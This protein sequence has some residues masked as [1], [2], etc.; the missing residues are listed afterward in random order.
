VLKPYI[1][2]FTEREHGRDTFIPVYKIFKKDVNIDT[3]LIWWG[4]ERKGLLG[5]DFKLGPIKVNRKP[6]VLIVFR[7]WWGQEGKAAHFAARQ[8]IPVVMI[9]HGA[10]FVFNDRQK[11]KKSIYPAS[12]N[13]LWGQHDLDLW[14][15]WGNKDKLVVTGNPLYDQIIE[16]TP[17][18]INLPDEFALLLPS[19]SNVQQRFLIPSAEKLNKII[20]VVVKTHPLEKEKDYYKQRYLT[21]DKS[22]TL[23]PL[24][25]KAK[26][27]ITH[28][29]SAV[30]PGLFWQ[31]PI[32]MHSYDESWYYFS[33]FKDKYFH[34]FNF[35]QD[36]VWNSEVISKAIKPD[37]KHFEI[38]GHI[39]DGKN[40]VRV[41]EVIKS[42][43]K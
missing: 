34:I 11:Y 2:F 32:F 40:S 41:A 35:K 3:T 23:L 28:S 29:T 1:V 19:S 30:I 15:R 25:Y 18:K 21:Y 12:V 39:A 22:W 38:F 4:Q 14:R 42:Y 37:K 24:L 13:C 36:D 20:P 27:I 6:D 31:K 17:P 5:E 9:D 10:T 33:E 8:D 43:V 7:S 16:Y 26:L